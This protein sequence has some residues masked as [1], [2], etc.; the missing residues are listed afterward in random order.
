AKDA[1]VAKATTESE[2]VETV[3]I[4]TLDDAQTQTTVAQ[5]ENDSDD[6][7]AALKDSADNAAQTA[8]TAVAAAET[9]VATL[10]ANT[11][12]TAADIAIAQDAI[13]AGDAA[14]ATAADAKKAYETAAVDADE[15][16]ETTTTVGSTTSAQADLNTAVQIEIDSDAEVA[17]DLT[18][19]IEAAATAA[20]SQAAANTASTTAANAQTTADTKEAATGDLI[21]SATTAKEA[22]DGTDGAEATLTAAEAAGQAAVDS[23]TE[24]KANATTLVDSATA[25]LTAANAALADANNAVAEAQ[26]A[27]ASALAANEDTSSQEAALVEAQA[28]QVIATT[29]VT[30]AGTA[31]THANAELTQANATLEAATTLDRAIEA[32]TDAEVAADLATVNSLI[33]AADA[34]TTAA[35][36]AATA[37]DAATATADANPTVANLKLA[38][39]AQEAADSASTTVTN[40]ANDLQSAVTSLAASAVAADETVNLD[41]ATAAITNANEAAT[42]ATSSGSVVNDRVSYVLDSDTTANVINENVPDGTY[43]GVTL[44]AT[45]VDGDAITYSVEDGVPFTMG[46]NGQIVT[47]GEI[48]FETKESYTFTVTATSTDNTASKLLI[49]INVTP[50]DEATVTVEDSNSTN[51]DTILTVDKLSG[52]LSNDSDVDNALSVSSFTVAGDATVYT[53]DSD[54]TTAVL[55]NGTVA[56][57][58]L[59]LNVDGSYEFTPADNWS[60]DVPE[61]T[62]TTN[63]GISNTLTLTVNAVADAP[64]LSVTTESTVTQSITLANVTDTESGFTITTKDADGND[65]T[66]SNHSGPDGFGVAGRASGA[67]SE[68][69]KSESLSVAFDNDVSSVDV[70][71]AWLASTESATYTFMKGGKQVGSG[72]VDGGSDGVDAA[73][74]LTP[75]NGA[76]FDEIIFTASG[77]YDDYLINSITFDKAVN[78][79][80]TGPIVIDEKSSVALNITSALTDTDGSESLAVVLKDIPEGFTLTDGT[81]SFTADAD[82]TSIDITDWSLDNLT[83]TPIDITDE[84]SYTLKVVATAAESSDNT[85]STIS[86][87]TITV[88]PVNGQ[89]LV[90]GDGADT[91]TLTG[92]SNSDTD[93][94]ALGTPAADTIVTNITMDHSIIDTGAGADTVTINPV[95]LSENVAHNTSINTGSGADTVTVNYILD[96]STFDTGAGADT[97]TLTGVQNGSRVNTGVDIGADT[98]TIGSVSDSSVDTGGGADTLTVVNV[99]GSVVNAGD[100]INTVTLTTVEGSSIST[101]K[102]ADTVTINGKMVDST[103]NTGTGIDTVTIA[104][105]QGTSTISTGDGADT[106]SITQVSDT[107]KLDSGA[108]F[109]TVTLG[110]VEDG[111]DGSVNLGNDVDTLTINLD[112]NATLGVNATFDGGEGLDTLSLTGVTKAEW[113]AGVKD[114]FVNFET[115]NIGRIAIDMTVTDAQTVDQKITVSDDMKPETNVM[116]ILDISGSM[117]DYSR[118]TDAKAAI[119]ALLVG[120]GEQA[121]VSIKVIGFDG[122]T[123]SSIWLTGDDAVTKATQFVSSLSADKNGGTG[124]K[125]AIEA[126]MAEFNSGVTSGQIDAS[127]GTDI[128]FISDGAPGYGQGI[129]YDYY[130]YYNN[131]SG[132]VR[133]EWEEFTSTYNITNVH[134]VGIG[135]SDSDQHVI[136]NLTPISLGEPPIVLSDSTQLKDVL[137]D[138]LD[139]SYVGDFL[140]DVS[141]SLD[142]EVASVTINGTVYSYN[143]TDEV[144]W[145]NA[146]QSPATTAGSSATIAMAYGSFEIDFETGS[147]KFTP[148]DVTQDQSETVDVVLRDSAHN[149]VEGQLT[150]NITDSDLVNDFKFFGEH[151]IGIYNAVSYHAGAGNDHIY[152]TSFNGK[153]SRFFG[154]EGDDLLEGRAG[155]DKL[156][157]GADNDILLGGSGSDTLSGD[158]GSDFLLGGSDN[159]MLIGGTGNDILTGGSGIDTFVWLDGDDGTVPATDHITDFNI[160]EDKLDLSDLLDGVETKDLGNYLELSF[161]SETDGTNTTTISIHADSDTSAVSQ[162]IIL[163]NV[164]LSTAYPG[165]DFTSTAGINSILNDADDLLGS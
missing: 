46:E 71:F 138:T 126:A 10:A 122:R 95:D 35:K 144:S 87:V 157:G 102:D 5:A 139:D 86:E 28:A 53:V 115:V 56:I 26:D 84:T 121:D 152:D 154:D 94:A 120:Y 145:I 68:L 31:L 158:S 67:D 42:N 105:A 41:D 57:G 80:V 118:L 55:T 117:Q 134:T 3:T 58:S 70:A 63:T 6:A 60:G 161:G 148:V 90:T 125:V 82:K 74:T 119:N 1:Y 110:L 133:A 111:F 93:L 78:E 140:S 62:Y 85:S 91:I 149:T 104:D 32:Q 81:N 127:K 150:I 79:I 44:A 17:A 65:S 141:T 20:S 147:Y 15:I 72:T 96:N 66:I 159:D 27:L 160:L 89:T 18:T 146:D 123:T 164:D 38:Q 50:V 116:V 98:V 136:N 135:V 108:G 13:D 162:V 131:G 99:D 97:I 77:S 25:S 37:A 76:L 165:V 23:A 22:I 30:D 101:G 106:V 43:T 109:D 92:V 124:Y 64:A 8:N 151:N 142:S 61:V 9:A 129:T 48:D 29:S 11:N 156:Y 130:N 39:E 132:G 114:H 75:N 19:A 14:I 107:V 69:G 155:N 24:Y 163:D 52:V 113:D 36:N 73:I 51:E 137:Q 112:E 21:T 153:N 143:G 16:V 45:D 33:T 40:A 59:T 54:G 103:L 88:T 7:V 2:V 12:P 4:N 83:L 128:Y 49:T 34:A 47:S 100:G